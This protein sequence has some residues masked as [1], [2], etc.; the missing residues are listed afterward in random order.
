MGNNSENEYRRWTTKV[1]S[2]TR[3]FGVLLLLVAATLCFSVIKFGLDSFL[4]IASIIAFTLCGI[5]WFFYLKY[6]VRVE[7]ELKAKA[8]GAEERKITNP[9]FQEIFQEY[10]YDRF[11]GVIQSGYFAKWKLNEVYE[12]DQAIDII[13]TNKE[14]EIALT[15]SNDEVSIFIDEETDDPI[16]QTIPLVDD[17]YKDIYLLFADIAKICE[18]ALGV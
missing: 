17:K 18:H 13:Y 11:E 14:H 9:I 15:I 2:R 7:H 6:L 8:Y 5:G 3:T 10:Q 4:A 12:Y 1:A 16:I